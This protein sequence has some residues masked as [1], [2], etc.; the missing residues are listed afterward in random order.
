MFQLVRFTLYVELKGKSNT[1][2]SVP[3]M[4]KVKDEDFSKT[5]NRKSFM[6]Q[7]L[8]KGENAVDKISAK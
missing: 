7:H 1:R 8:A 6:I 3:M 2:I 5:S 4:A